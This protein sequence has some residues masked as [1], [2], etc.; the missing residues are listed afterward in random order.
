[1][2]SHFQGRRVLVTGH[3]GFKGSWLSLWLAELGAEV[4]GYAL[5]P[6]TTPD[7]FGLARV[8]E[9]VNDGRGDVRDPAALARRFAEARPEIVFHLAAQP[10]VR[11]SYDAPVDTFATNVMGT[12][13]VL[14]QV[15]L[16]G[17]PCTVVVVTTD[18]VYE[19]THGAYACR[20]TDPLG[21]YDPYSAS[22]A[23]AEI[24]TSSYAR[25]FFGA[26]SGVRVASARAGNVIGGG[27]FAPDRLVPDLVRAIQAGDALTL[28]H[29]GA[30]R[31]WQHVLEPLSGYLWLAAQLAGEGGE[32]FAGG[33]NFGPAAD[34]FRTVLDLA[35]RAS[36][37]LTETPRPIAIGDADPAKHEMATLTLSI[38][39]AQQRLRW[40]PVWRIER[41][42]DETM[43]WYHAVRGGSSGRDE[44]M[45]QIAA[46]EADA[47]AARLPWAQPEDRAA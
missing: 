24:V 27:D 16:A 32:R 14:E 4:F 36:K 1:M 43:R 12:A 18:K 45:K 25:S 17:R 10:L 2:R 33:W 15:R 26:G 35:T 44:T 39:K 20:E 19:D 30:V 23:A 34:D 5:D 8:A 46:Y 40:S 37:V 22:K 9:V 42:V 47:R 3:T 29:P 21:G 28:R 7:L 11:A 13:N 6:A 38:D 41:A 31:P